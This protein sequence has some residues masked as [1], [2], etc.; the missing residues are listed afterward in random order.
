MLAERGAPKR[1]H[2]DAGRRQRAGDAGCF[3]GWR[4]SAAE[5]L[6]IRRESSSALLEQVRVELAD[7]SSDAGD[8]GVETAEL[9]RAALEAAE[10]ARVAAVEREARA[11]RARQVLARLLTAENTLRTA[12][13]ARLDELLVERGGIEEELT[14]AAGEREAALPGLLRSAAAVVRGF[15][16]GSASRRPG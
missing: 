13:Q 11:E 4:G 9:E 10:A 1:S 12:A 16:G 6:G 8:P 7:A 15:G 2:A 14:G 5:R 3:T